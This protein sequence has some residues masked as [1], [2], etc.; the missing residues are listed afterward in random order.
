[1]GICAVEYLSAILAQMATPVLTPLHCDLELRPGDP[2]QTCPIAPGTR[3]APRRKCAQEGEERQ[4]LQSQR[5]SM[6]ISAG[7]MQ[8]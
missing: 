3:S 7:Q 2:T 1:M 4:V 5:L 8:Q 6:D